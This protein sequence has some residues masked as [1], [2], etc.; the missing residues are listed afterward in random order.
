MVLTAV[1]R[2]CGFLPGA[3]RGNQERYYMVKV[4]LDRR[5]PWSVG[6]RG[7]Q[8]GRQPVI[9]TGERNQDRPER[10]HLLTALPRRSSARAWC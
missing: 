5:R 3:A 8:R 1:G 10:G 7:P 9:K 6:S 2:D 4:M